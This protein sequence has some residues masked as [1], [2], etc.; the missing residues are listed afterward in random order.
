M[1]YAG[2]WSR[3]VN[4]NSAS[5]MLCALGQDLALSGHNGHVPHLPTEE[6]WTE[7]RLCTQSLHRIP[8]AGKLKEDIWTEASS[9]AHSHHQILEGNMWRRHLPGPKVDSTP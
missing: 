1:E 2:V 9:P 7:Q 6:G 4:V 5:Y 8:I 3:A